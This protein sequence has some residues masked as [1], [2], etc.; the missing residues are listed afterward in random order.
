MTPAPVTKE[1]AGGGSAGV[2][3]YLVVGN[4]IAHSR[5]PEIHAAFARQTGQAVSYGRLLVPVDPPGAFAAAAGGFFADGG[6]GLNVTL[7][8]KVDA[9]DYANR[10]SERALLAGAVNTLA[11][12]DGGILGDNTDGPGLVADLQDRLG[13]TLAGRSVLLLGAGGAARGVVMPLLQAGVAMLTVANRSRAR[14]EQLALAFN[15]SPVLRGAGL[16]RVRAV[17]QEAAASAD[18][19]VNA[20]S[21]S[22][23]GG[24][25]LLPPGLFSGCR[26]AYDC[27]YGP[28]PSDFMTQALRGGA[29]QVSDGLGMLV[30]QAAES[31]L[32]WRGVRP[33][34]SPVYRMLR[35]LIAAPTDGA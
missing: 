26:L 30:E 25:L 28:T 13:V 5:S 34:T 9:F 14:A 10:H 22:V 35:D 19:I 20:T 31:F 23:L 33:S 7:P 18:L 12:G 2:D 32:V 29:A 1:R 3:R 16:P 27:A 6:R 8:F 21:S 11:A 15:E 4:P 17:A 24:S